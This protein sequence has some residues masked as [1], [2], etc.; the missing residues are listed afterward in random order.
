MVSGQPQGRARIVKDCEDVLSCCA[1]AVAVELVKRSSEAVLANLDLS[2][3]LRSTSLNLIHILK[4][5]EMFFKARPW[6]LEKDLTRSVDSVRMEN[7]RQN[8]FR[9]VLNRT[10]RTTT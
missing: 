5:V 7:P 8:N 9:R 6:R 4:L 10:L 1:M 2:H 3:P